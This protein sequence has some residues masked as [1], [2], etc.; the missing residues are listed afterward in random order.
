MYPILYKYE[1]G[2]PSGAALSY[3]TTELPA[4]FRQIILLDIFLYIQLIYSQTETLHLSTEQKDSNLMIEG[5]YPVLNTS[6][7]AQSSESTIHM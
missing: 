3:N 1:D 5:P 7:G 2:I 4:I 6:H